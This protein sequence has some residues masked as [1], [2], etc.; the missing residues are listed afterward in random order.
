MT[1]WKYW[2]FY[3]AAHCCCWRKTTLTTNKRFILF[4]TFF[5]NIHLSPSKYFLCCLILD[6]HPTCSDLWAHNAISSLN[7]HKNAFKITRMDMLFSCECVCFTLISSNFIRSFV[8]LLCC[9]LFHSFFKKKSVETD[10]YYSVIAIFCFL[11]S[12]LFI[13]KGCFF[14][15][16][17]GQKAVLCLK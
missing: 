14:S 16:S 1:S 10:Q 3:L 17:R 13:C 9:S 11:Q 6:S 15:I 5:V 2:Y 8:C 4:V 7:F 12:I